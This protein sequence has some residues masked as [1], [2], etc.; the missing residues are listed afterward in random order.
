SSLLSSGRPTGS[1]FNRTC[2]ALPNLKYMHVLSTI[3]AI[4]VSNP[5]IARPLLMGKEKQQ[6][7]AS[8]CKGK[9][10]GWR[11]GGKW[12]I[13]DRNILT[14]HLTPY[15]LFARTEIGNHRKVR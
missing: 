3:P 2:V 11:N 1:K 6:A 8:G 4:R 5:A 15:C 13:A 10:E 14:F 12:K 9:R 7:E